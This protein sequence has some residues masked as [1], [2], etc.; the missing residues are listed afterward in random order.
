MVRD[1]RRA[2]PGAHR[3][4]HHD[5]FHRHLAPPPAWA[6]GRRVREVLLDRDDELATLT[7]RLGLARAGAGRVIVVDGPAG[8]GK[9]SLLT[10]IARAAKADGTVVLAARGGPLEQDAAWGIAR[11]LFEPLRREPGWGGLTVGAAAL[12]ERALDA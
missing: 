2:A 1:R 11:R 8:I 12:A 3:G 6:Y 9:S 7:R 4:A 10:A 5:L